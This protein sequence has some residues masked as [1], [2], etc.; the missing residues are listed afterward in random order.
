MKNLRPI[1]FAKA[2]RRFHARVKKSDDLVKL[3]LTQTLEKL[4]PSSVIEKISRDFA[5]QV[6]LVKGVIS[7]GS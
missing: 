4:I 6:R 3:H 7:H 2:H 5:H 1:F